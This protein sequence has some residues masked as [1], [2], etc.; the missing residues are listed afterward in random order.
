[1]AKWTELQDKSF[2]EATAR[3]RA[4]GI[5][6]E[7][8]FTEFC[9]PFDKIYSPHLPLMGEAIEY[10]DGLVAGVGKIGK[11]PIFVISQEG[12]FIGGSIGE[13]SGAKMVKTIQLAS[14]LYEEM[15]SEKP[16]LPEEMRPAVVIS[17][18]TGGVRLHEANA[19]LLAHAE[20]MDQIQNCRGR[21]PII[22]LIGSRVGCFGGM[23]FVAAA[24]D[25]IIMS[26]FGRLGLTG[27][28]VIEQ[29]MGKD[30]FDASDR[31]LVYRT[32]GGKHKY[33][34]GDCNYL[35]ADSIR[36]FRE[37]TTAV[38]Q[39]PMEEIETFRRIGSMEKI[40]EQIE[41]VKLSV[42][43]KPKDSMDVW[44]HAGNENPESLINM[45]LD[46][47]LAQAKRLKA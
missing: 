30:E 40:K 44:A 43:L 15:V 3:E 5:V 46:E 6:D 36:S 8:T 18:E 21:V 9:G 19:G 2:L 23:G 32:T 38:L 34:I 17:F 35:A 28:E 41:L 39:K 7:G 12:R 47:F 25:V 31:A 22:S 24:T 42:S 20:V 1:M 45:T 11:K 27:P 33:I 16:D 14:D 4:V 13:V 26:Q 29:E 37:T 10:D